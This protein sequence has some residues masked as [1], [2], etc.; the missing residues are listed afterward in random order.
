MP[1]TR[2]KRETAQALLT[3]LGV[4][5]HPVHLTVLATV[6]DGL[7]PEAKADLAQFLVGRPQPRTYFSEREG[8]FV[9]EDD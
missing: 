4:D 2:L 8:G 6:L 9:T 1:R 7:S 5:S 3:A